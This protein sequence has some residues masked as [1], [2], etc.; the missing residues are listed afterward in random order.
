MREPLVLSE[1][2]L[3][4]PIS[5]WCFVQKKRV[6]LLGQ[7]PKEQEG[8]SAHDDYGLGLTHQSFPV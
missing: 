6:R 5:Q 1:D 4:I 3:K 2:K 7:R 8:R